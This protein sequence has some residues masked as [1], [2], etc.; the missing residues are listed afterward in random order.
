MSPAKGHFVQVLPSIMIASSSLGMLRTSMSHELVAQQASALLG[1]PEGNHVTKVPTCLDT[2]TDPSE[3]A[4]GD[5]R[6]CS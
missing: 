4:A 3:R 6:G 5:G 2:E 1:W